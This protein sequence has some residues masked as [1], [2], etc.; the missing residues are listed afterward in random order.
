MVRLPLGQAYAFRSHAAHYLVQDGVEDHAQECE[1]DGPLARQP[2]HPHY[3][4]CRKR[5]RRRDHHGDCRT[6]RPPDASSLQPHPDESK[7]RGP[8]GG[9]SQTPEF[10]R[11]EHHIA[12]G[13]LSIAIGYPWGDLTE[14]FSQVTFSAKSP[15]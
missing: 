2:A 3:G 5:R 11:I 6:R 1:G 13:C 8:G 14:F 4:T 7:T 9:R 15:A 12:T 10:F